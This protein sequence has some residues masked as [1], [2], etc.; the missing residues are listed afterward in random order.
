MGGASLRRCS[1][2]SPRSNVG[3]RKRWPCADTGHGA[4]GGGVRRLIAVVM[5]L[6]L[7]AAARASGIYS[8]VEI[9]GLRVAMDA[10]WGGQLAPGYLPVRFDISNADAARVIEIVVDCNRVPMRG[11]YPVYRGPRGFAA[12]TTTVVQTVRL[13][14]GE[15]V[16]FTLPV[17]VLGDSAGLQFRIRENGR[18]LQ[19]LGG[20]SLQSGGPADDTAVLIAA[21]SSTPFGRVATT[22]LR[23]VAPSR[24]PFL[25]ASPT[26]T[27]SGLPPFDFLLDP[28]RL[29]TNWIGFTSVRAVVIGPTEWKQLSEE[30]QSALRTWTACGGDLVLVDGDFAMLLPAGSRSPIVYAGRATV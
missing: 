4:A 13:A 19:D 14:R 29:P 9:E 27:T 12:S 2:P 3:C 24:G 21:G 1:N 23:S 22:W 5:L 18:P 10:E 7:P 16:R 26:P 17:P 25:R 8:S 28:T 15:R 30:Q 20:M 11:G 6:L